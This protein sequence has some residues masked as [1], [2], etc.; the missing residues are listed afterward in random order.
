MLA[1]GVAL[2]LAFVGAALVAGEELDVVFRAILAPFR[3]KR[4]PGVV[5]VVVV[6]WLVRLATRRVRSRNDRPARRGWGT[7]AFSPAPELVLPLIV[8]VAAACRIALDRTAIGPKILGDELIYTGLAKSLA[9]GEGFAVRG[10]HDI[11]HSVLFP[12]LLAPAYRLTESGVAAYEVIKIS[13]A[14][15]AALAAVPI[16]WLARRGLSDRVALIVAALAVLPV[17]SAYASLAMTESFFYPLLMTFA[18]S[19]VRALEHPT[20]ARQLATLT[21]LALCIGTRPQALALVPALATAVLLPSKGTTILARARAFLPTWG[22]LGGIAIGSVVLRV[23]GGR[24][25]VS[26]SGDLATSYDAVDLV[27]WAIRHLAILDL[28]VGVVCF[29]LL[30][31]AWALGLRSRDR[32]VNAVT[33]TAV[34]L[35]G[36]LFASVVV[37]SASPYGLERLHERNLFYLYPLMVICCV[38][39]IGKGLR[40]SGKLS[41]AGSVCAVGLPGA[42]PGS[43]IHSSYDAITMNVWAE[44]NATLARIAPM[45]IVMS[46]AA[47]LLCGTFAVRR[48]RSIA[49]VSSGAALLIAGATALA[50]REEGSYQVERLSWVD[51]ALKDSAVDALLLYL[52]PGSRECPDDGTVDRTYDLSIAAEYYSRRVTTVAG[53]DHP[54]PGFLAAQPI[55]VGDDGVVLRNGVPIRERYVITD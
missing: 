39:A 47:L 14:V 35:I 49:L 54:G 19:L 18:L 43:L 38:G 33:R 41:I 53:L 6:L 4:V 26:S 24:L 28:G 42:L 12:L 46:L 2:G 3:P 21:L 20:M 36:W 34:A 55:A 40:L 10:A 7:R 51:N 30:P 17:F 52:G 9:A 27:T 11:G 37:L 29:A 16:F 50:P 15:L 45:Q 31:A 23:S 48:T 1:T 8:G 13:N 32:G 44:A 22:V 5:G 25:P